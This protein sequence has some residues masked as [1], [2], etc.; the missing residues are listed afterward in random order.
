MADDKV[1][2][3]VKQRIEKLLEEKKVLL[4]K[5]KGIMAKYKALLVKNKENESVIG[6]LK[7]SLEAAKQ[8]AA[9]IDS[10]SGNEEEIKKLKQKLE[11]TKGQ[12]SR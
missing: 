3:E 1:D 12:N 7:G 6:A 2:A 5:T 10:E 4:G 11:E 8:E 9:E